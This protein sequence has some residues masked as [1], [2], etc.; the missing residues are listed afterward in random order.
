MKT[1]PVILCTDFAINVIATVLCI[2]R[3][4]PLF[5]F[6]ALVLAFAVLE[7]TV[8]A[9]GWSVLPWVSRMLLNNQLATYSRMCF[10]SLERAAD[11]TYDRV[12]RRRAQALRQQEY[13][14]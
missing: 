11:S 4:L 2:L 6:Y 12:N 9:L 7:W 5:P 8:S 3:I 10:K 14:L 13:D 1:H